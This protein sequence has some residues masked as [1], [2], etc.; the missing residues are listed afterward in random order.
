MM[1]GFM[2]CMLF[3]VVIYIILCAVEGWNGELCS[4][5][6]LDMLGGDA[7]HAALP[8]GGYGNEF[9]LLEVLKVSEAIAYATIAARGCGVC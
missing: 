3:Y 5:N 6:M 9:R 4:R 7:P 2:L 1:A 8:A